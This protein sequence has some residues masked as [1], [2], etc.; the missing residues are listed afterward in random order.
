M[1]WH[2]TLVGPFRGRLTSSL[3][4][5][6]SNHF[7]FAALHIKTSC[8]LGGGNILL[9]WRKGIVDTPWK[10]SK[11]TWKSADIQPSEGSRNSAGR[12]KSLTWNSQNVHVLYF[13]L[14]KVESQFCPCVLL[15]LNTVILLNIV[16]DICQWTV[17]L[18][19]KIKWKFK[20]QNKRR[21]ICNA[22]PLAVFT[23]GW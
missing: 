18:L 6:F 19:L 12:P 1:Q 22:L 4:Y 16:W 2:Y 5:L 8:L 14:E 20:P 17:K 13:Y 15:T 23:W 10:Y 11:S 21:P 3:S 7:R 9:H